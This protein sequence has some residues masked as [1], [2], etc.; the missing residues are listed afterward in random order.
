MK[1][2]DQANVLRI[3]NSNQLANDPVMKHNTKV[4][5][6]DK[7][8]FDRFTS[9]IDEI[10]HQIC[11]YIN[12]KGRIDIDVELSKKFEQTIH[13]SNYNIK[14]LNYVHQKVLRVL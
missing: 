8:N 5:W 1:D 13:L 10:N 14:K 7:F 6:R 11:D 4:L 12:S 9:S 3:L 2:F